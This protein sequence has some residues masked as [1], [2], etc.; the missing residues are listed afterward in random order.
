MRASLVVLTYNQ[1]KEGTIPCMESI[2]RYTPEGEY[3]LVLVDNASS[4]GTPEH[5]RSFAEGRKDVKLVLNKENKGYAGG[6]NDGLRR[7][8]R[9]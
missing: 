8:E 4:D 7:R 2:V 1:L 3:E 9:R 6:N 5:L